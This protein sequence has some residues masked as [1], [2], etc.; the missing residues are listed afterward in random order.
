MAE[1]CADI[2]T[3]SHQRIRRK[4]ALVIA[5]GLAVAVL[6]LVLLCY[7][8]GI[9]STTDVVA[10]RAMWRERYHP[11]WKDL[12]LRRVKKGDDVA[13]LVEKHPPL[14]R[15]DAGPYTKL[16]YTQGGADPGLTVMAENGR[17]A[18]AVAGAPT[19]QHVFFNAPGPMASYAQ[20]QSE[21][22][23]R[24]R[25][26]KDAYRIHCALTAGRN[27]FLSDRIERR[28]LVAQVSA[29]P[30]ADEEYQRIVAIIRAESRREE[31]TVEV[32]EVVSGDVEPGTTLTFAKGR[33][34]DADLE[35]AAT[36]FL[37]TETKGRTV[38]MTVP[39]SA[40]TWY[41]SLTPEE[42][43]ALEARRSDR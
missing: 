33:C 20:A 3:E 31:L 38:Y 40:L 39:Y 27:V 19:W 36:V 34:D 8:A 30:G 7:V 37:A 35:E 41:Q 1:E 6:L 9:R 32:Q 21:Y 13:A 42:I 22:R 23:K 12:A 15:N 2:R 26:D 18:L 5:G 4:V 10:Y 14:Y 24:L 17:L 29:G 25:L 28:T 16:V 43:Q 11:I